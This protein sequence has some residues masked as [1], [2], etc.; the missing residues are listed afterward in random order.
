MKNRE[1]EDEKA[2]EGQFGREQNANFLKKNNK[3]RR[4]HS[5]N[6]F[7]FVLSQA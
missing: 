4:K 7:H 5:M 1:E 6:M 3:F 2:A